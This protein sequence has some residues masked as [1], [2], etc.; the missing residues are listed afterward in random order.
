MKQRELMDVEEKEDQILYV[1]K[2]KWLKKN[3]PQFLR[4]SQA[5]Q[6]KRKGFTQL[7]KQ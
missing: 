1:R 7:C 6:K 5:S 3:M 4:L 2:K